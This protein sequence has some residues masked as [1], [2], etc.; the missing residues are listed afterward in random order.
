M[1]GDL[2]WYENRYAQ[3]DLTDMELMMIETSS[4]ANIIMRNTGIQFINQD[5]YLVD[6]STLEDSDFDTVMNYLDNCKDV[7][8][9][10]QSDKNANGFGD[11]CEPPTVV[12]GHMIP[13]DTTALMLAG[14]QNTAVW[15][16]PVLVS[17]IGFGIVILRK[18]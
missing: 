6:E 9:E 4:L 16:I 3:G 12:G 18:I 15:L 14:T 2:Y 8:N 1:D 10:D 7:W 13:L 5:V 11:V 17:A